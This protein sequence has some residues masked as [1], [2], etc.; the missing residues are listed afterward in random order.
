MEFPYANDT[1]YL[2]HCYPYTYTDLTNDLNDLLADPIR[3]QYVKKDSMCETK[4]GNSCYLLT[5]TDFGE[6]LDANI[7]HH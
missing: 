4:S 5:I 6:P 3:S 1:C 2:A 7:L